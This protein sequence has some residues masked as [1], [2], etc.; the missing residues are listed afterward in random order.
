MKRNS[1]PFVRRSTNFDIR[2]DN[3]RGITNRFDEEDAKTIGLGTKIVNE[4]S[5]FACDVRRIE[6]GHVA[7][8]DEEFTGVFQ[9]FLGA[10]AKERG[11][12]EA[13]AEGFA[14]T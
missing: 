13:E 1:T 12:G 6:N 4:F 5:A 11:E 2:F 7:A 14:F 9:R 3:F 10:L 8:F